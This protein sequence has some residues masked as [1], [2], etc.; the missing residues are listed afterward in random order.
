[1]IVP[2]IKKT[3]L[4]PGFGINASDMH[5]FAKI[6]RTARQSPIVFGISP[7]T[8]GRKNMLDLKRKIKNYFRGMAILAAMS[9]P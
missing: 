7:S 1:M 4:R 6:A 5:C 9:R 3:N 8:R 2:W